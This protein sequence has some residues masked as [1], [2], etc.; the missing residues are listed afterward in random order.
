MLKKNDLQKVLDKTSSY[1]VCSSP[2]FI[3]FFKQNNY[4][5]TL[6]ANIPEMLVMMNA[7]IIEHGESWV[8]IDGVLP[9]PFYC[10]EEDFVLS[11]APADDMNVDIDVL[12]K[13]WNDLS[14]DE[15]RNTVE[16]IL[17]PIDKK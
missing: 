6:V 15:K 10:E 5:L 13:K 14:D 2:I 16:F 11:V 1:K 9:Y 12:R 4:H 17:N 7:K 8:I 3:E